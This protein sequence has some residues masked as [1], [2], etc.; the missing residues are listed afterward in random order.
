MIADLKKARYF[1]GAA[2]RGILYAG[3][4]QEIEDLR[5]ALKGLKK[6]ARRAAHHALEYL[7]AGGVAPEAPTRSE[8]KRFL[9]IQEA[10]IL[11][12][13]SRLARADLTDLQPDRLSGSK[14]DL[15]PRGAESERAP[16]RFQDRG[17][18]PLRARPRAGHCPGRKVDV[19]SG[20]DL[21]PSSS[22][23]SSR[24]PGTPSSSP[25]ET[26]DDR[27][28]RPEPESRW[29]AGQ[30]S[31]LLAAL[32]HDLRARTSRLLGSVATPHEPSGTV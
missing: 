11:G 25:R 14:G 24:A 16:G 6:D 30:W 10:S 26:R 22:L 27:P 32:P 9:A 4:V 1:G 12:A 17:P 28:V 21:F 23:L 29:L 18:L 2:V 5:A 8:R 19:P 13:L 31:D 3:K 20:P 15:A 7:K